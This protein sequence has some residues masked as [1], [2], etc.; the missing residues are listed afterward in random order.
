MVICE[1]ES[2]R[3][4]RTACLEDCIGTKAPL[5]LKLHKPPFGSSLKN[6]TAA[7]VILSSIKRPLWWDSISPKGGRINES[8][9]S[10]LPG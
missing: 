3:H 4:G 5:W 2:T 1:I 7:I 9:C 10:H 8:K 6:P